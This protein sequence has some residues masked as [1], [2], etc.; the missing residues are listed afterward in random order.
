MR[1]QKSLLHAVVLLSRSVEEECGGREGQTLGRKQIP[2]P[3]TIVHVARSARRYRLKCQAH[4]S[5]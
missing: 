4:P 2:S 3:G 1:D 5:S